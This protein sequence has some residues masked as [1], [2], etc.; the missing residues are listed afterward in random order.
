M[1]IVEKNYNSLF[2]LAK[3]EAM[4][5]LAD[6]TQAEDI[7][8]DTIVAL[9][10]IGDLSE[11][12][13][14]GL[15]KTIAGRKAMNH[16]NQETRRREIEHEHSHKIRNESGQSAHILAADPL[17]IMA[18]EEMKDRLDELSPLLYS[19]VQAYYINGRDIE[20]IADQFN[21]TPNVIYQRLHKARTI[22]TG[23]TDE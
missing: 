14:Y 16:N 17:E 21:T 2:R 18:Y 13:M 7:A 22:V 20:E 15:C 9:L 4:I 12:T 23:E 8:Q 19:T 1:G 3:S 10:E 5:S 6:Q 11:S